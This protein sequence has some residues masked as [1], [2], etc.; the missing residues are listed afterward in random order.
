MERKIRLAF[1]VGSSAMKVA[2]W[3]GKT[4]ELH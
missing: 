3:R 1:D 2:L 4:L